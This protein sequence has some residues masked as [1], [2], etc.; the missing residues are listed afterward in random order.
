MG[1][2]YPRPSLASKNYKVQEETILTKS[3]KNLK[4]LLIF[5]TNADNMIN[6]RNEIQLLAS[7][8]SSDVICIT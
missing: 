3:K 5:Y 6:K 4:K 7:T 1:V 2:Q 8:N